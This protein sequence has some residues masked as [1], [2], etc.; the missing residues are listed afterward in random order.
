M[1]RSFLIPGIFLLALTFSA[2][3]LV[4]SG[5]AAD[6]TA[7]KM[8]IEKAAF[9]TT[10]DGQAVELYTL[11]N[12]NGI[13][14]KAITYG[15]IIYSVETPDR[16][17]RFT[18]ITA[19]CASL[20]GYETKSP[21]FGALLG[22]YANRISGAKFPL[23]GREIVLSRNAGANHIH[24]G[25]RG[26]DKR[27]W[28]AE[29]I[30]RN[31]YVALKLSYTSKDGEE[32]YPGNLTCTV[33]YEL[34]NKN[35]WRM[36][37]TAQTDK[38]TVINLSNHAYWNLSGAQSGTILEHILKVNAAKY[39]LA[40]AALIPTGESVS[41]QGT[42]LDFREPHAI[43]ERFDRITGKQFGG[44]Y[45]HCL[46]LQHEAPAD[47]TFCAKLIDP[48]SGRTMEVFTTQPAV[49]IFTANFAS[50]AFEGPDGYR[51]PKHLG[52]CLETQHFPDSPNKRNFPST[53][54]RPGETFHSVTVHKF[55]VER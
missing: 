53:I 4:E 50:G 5:R 54:L 22:R 16:E 55:G 11:R 24:G 15:G 40:D 41:V 49:Q 44:G 23:D 31:D 42:P 18:N 27:V 1:Q 45:D 29:A 20:S 48:K 2:L 30:Q 38:P 33:V 10:A 35:E 52:V 26:F 25:T 46:V 9:G 36:E 19:N 39:L 47:L 8:S 7:F 28:K 51:Y 17:G 37:Y 21:C 32:G 6:K 12:E 3:N 34:N 14:V 13:T 43:G